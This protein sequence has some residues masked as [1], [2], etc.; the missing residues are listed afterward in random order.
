MSMPCRHCKLSSKLY[1]PVHPSDPEHDHARK[2][3]QHDPLGAFV[4][5]L[6]MSAYQGITA[7]S[8]IMASYCNNDLNKITV[9]GKSA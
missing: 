7:Y 1:H 8:Y 9:R 2:A 4:H 6:C 3:S 5:Y